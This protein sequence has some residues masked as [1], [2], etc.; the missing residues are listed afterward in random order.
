MRW[1]RVMVTFNSDVELAG[2]VATV[3]GHPALP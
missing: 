2:I 3:G 1:K